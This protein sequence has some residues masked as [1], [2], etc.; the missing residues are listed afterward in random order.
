M[1][2]ARMSRLRL[3]RVA[4]RAALAAAGHDGICLFLLHFSSLHTCSTFSAS[5]E[6]MSLIAGGV[7]PRKD[8]W[9]AYGKQDAGSAT[10]FKPL[11][12]TAPDRPNRAA[13]AAPAMLRHAVATVPFVPI[14]LPERECSVAINKCV[15]DV[16]IIAGS[17]ACR[18]SG[19]IVG[20]SRTRIASAVDTPC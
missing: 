4:H 9:E 19:S 20:R 17:F 11:Q 5:S 8:D 10:R 1:A 12:A 16:D 7:L 13:S 14:A 2:D 6:L 15:R 18:P 3:E